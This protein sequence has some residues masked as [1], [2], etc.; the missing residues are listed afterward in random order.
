MCLIQTLLAAFFNHNFAHT[1]HLYLFI[2]KSH[3]RKPDAFN[4]RYGDEDLLTKRKASSKTVCVYI[5]YTNVRK[6]LSQKSTSRDPRVANGI[7][8]WQPD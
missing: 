2:I 1:K 5:V 8:C 6:L 7:L 3:L 4:C